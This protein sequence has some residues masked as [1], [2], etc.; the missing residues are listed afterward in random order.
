MRQK[1]IYQRILKVQEDVPYIRKDIKIDVKKDGRKVGEYPG[2]SHDAVVSALRDSMRKHGVFALPTVLP[3]STIEPMTRGY[4]YQVYVQVT[5]INVD[6]PEDRFICSV[7]AAADDY[8]DKGFGKCLSIA[9]KNAL[10]KVMMLESGENEE[11]RIEQK[12]AITKQEAEA[13]SARL[14]LLDRPEEDFMTWASK[15]TKTPINGFEDV[16][17]TDKAL[18]DSLLRKVEDKVKK[19]TPDANH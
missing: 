19:E 10:T 17:K 7:P 16:L 12:A 18:V 11:S 14:A 1:N 15:Y 8:G 13:F 4:R 5:F 2:L 9:F 3:D 6:V